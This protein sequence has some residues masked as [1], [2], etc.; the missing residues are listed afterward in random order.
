MLSYA[1]RLKDWDLSDECIALLSSLSL[2]LRLPRPS[3]F[4]VGYECEISFHSLFDHWLALKT[5]Q[6]KKKMKNE[7]CVIKESILILNPDISMH[8]PVLLFKYLLRC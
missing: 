1:C 8:I 3:G 7:S 5:S 4:T 6:I 2:V